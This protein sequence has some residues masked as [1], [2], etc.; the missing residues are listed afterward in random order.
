M[1]KKFLIALLFAAGLPLPGQSSA[2]PAAAPELSRDTRAI[3]AAAAP[4]YDFT[5]STL[6]PFHLKATYQLYNENG[7]PAEQGTWEYWRVSPKVYRSSWVR[8]DATRTE[9]RTADGTIYRKESGKPLRYFERN[10]ASSIFNPLPA[11]RLLESGALHLETNE[12]V[13][14]TQTMQCVVIVPQRIANGQPEAPSFFAG[15]RYCFDPSTH[16]LLLS[17][18]NPIDTEFNQI[19]KTQNHYLPREV[20][21]FAGKAKLF[22]LSIDTID[23]VAEGDAALTPAQ[24]AVVVSSPIPQANSGSP[25]SGVA[26]GTL[27]KKYAPVYPDTAKMAGAQGEVVLGATI[28]KD[29]RVRNL[30]VLATPSPLLSKPAMD[31]V[32][33]W[34]YSPYLL[35]GKPVEVETVI[36][37][38]FA[39]GR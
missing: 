29:G 7:K 33:H 20:M 38:Y 31:A 30:E 16:A 8:A 39:L 28:G 4:Y 11:E 3:L 5:D 32:S 9:W 18:S 14:G 35:N 12:L 17:I 26:S 24:D 13:L 34:E 25:A 1:R 15:H 22:T 2:S 27:I 37:V 10:I 36:N 6:K 21:F 23:G 19:V